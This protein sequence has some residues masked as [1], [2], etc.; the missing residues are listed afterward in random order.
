MIR[1][2]GIPLAILMMTSCAPKVT[3]EANLAASRTEVT[4]T[5]TPIKARPKLLTIAGDPRSP[6]FDESV[7]ERA[8]QAKLTSLRS[9]KLAGDDVELRVWVGFGKKPIEAFIVNRTGEKWEGTFLES[10]NLVNKP[11]FSQSLTP[12]AGWESIWSDLIAAG[13]YTLPDSSHLKDE[14]L[15]EDGTS[16]VVEIKQGEVYRTYSYINPDYQKWPEAKQMLRIA[17]ILYRGSAVERYP[18]PK[19]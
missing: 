11:P 4:P 13:L 2:I 1:I 3:R 12:K 5:P 8:H 9:K 17:D 6:Q 14:V 10:I 7:M 19:E 18:L 15:V 16:Y